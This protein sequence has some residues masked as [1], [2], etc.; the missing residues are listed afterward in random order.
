MSRSQA[1]IISKEY[2][3]A[4]FFNIK[5]YVVKSDLAKKYSS[6]QGQSRVII[7]TNYDELESLVLHTQVS[8]K[9]FHWLHGKIGILPYMG[10]AAILVMWPASC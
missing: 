9:S 6:I 3:T 7:W 1:V 5:A 2:I 10:M 8:S 4:T